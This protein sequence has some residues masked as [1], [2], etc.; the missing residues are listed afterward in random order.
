MRQQG[1]TLWLLSNP[2]RL[3]V[4]DCLAGKQSRWST[5]GPAAVDEEVLAR[6]HAGIVGGE[7][8]RHARQV[9][10]HQVAGQALHAILPL[11]TWPPGAPLS[12]AATASGSPRVVDIVPSLAARR[13]RA[14]PS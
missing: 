5:V 8:Q 4:E 1:V 11:S 7:E 3:I 13:K 14:A 12:T 2:G 9:L 6:D 10:G